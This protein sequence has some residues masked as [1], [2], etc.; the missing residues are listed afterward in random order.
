LYVGFK[1]DPRRTLAVQGENYW[2]YDTYD[3]DGMYQRRNE[4]LAG[5][6]RVAFLSFPSLK[7]AGTLHH[8]AEIVSFVD[9]A[10][11]KRWAEQP[12]KKRDQ[13]YQQL[14]EKISQALLDLVEK[15]LPGF[16]EQVAYCELSTPLST[17]Y[18][19]GYPQGNIYGI[20]AT[21]DR[22]R[23]KWIGLNTPLKGLY[24]TGSDA[25]AHGIAG[26]M[27]G[28]VLTAAAI[29]GLPRSL[30]TIFRTAFKYSK[31]LPE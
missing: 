31:T 3:H 24:L 28:G 20:P 2:I 5:K 17:E 14:K 30:I 11:F 18:Y 23:Q 12:I 21:P 9:Y 4:L 29:L 25:A 26:A 6:A 10:P 16:K 22:Y 13:D 7:N 15:H 27:M 19:T 1:D 8:T